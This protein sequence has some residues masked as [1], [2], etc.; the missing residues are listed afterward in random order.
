MSAAASGALQAA[1]FARLSADAALGAIVGGAIHDAV[2]PGPVPGL[3]VSLGEETIRDRS[4][5]TGRGAEHR[6][7]V[8]VISDAAGFAEAKAA[9]DAVSD[10]LAEA[11][12][13]LAR[14]R[15]VYLHFAS[16]RA[17]RTARGRMRRIDLTFVARTADE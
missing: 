14:G 8:S 10:A 3:F 15:L 11:D 2:P 12:L 1:V 6:F 13:T 16:A 9:A 17:R 7:V 4:D 5:M